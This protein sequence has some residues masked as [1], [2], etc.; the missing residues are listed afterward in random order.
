M[1]PTKG[2]GAVFPPELSGSHLGATEQVRSRRSEAGRGKKN[3]MLFLKGVF[4]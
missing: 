2:E 1:S 3:H 4:E